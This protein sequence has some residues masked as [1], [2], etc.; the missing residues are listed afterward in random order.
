[1]TCMLLAV[2]TLDNKWGPLGVQFILKVCGGGD[3]GY[4]MTFDPGSSVTRMLVTRQ[5]F[6]TVKSTWPRPK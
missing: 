5:Y 1:M 4:G 6:V 2:L 3:R